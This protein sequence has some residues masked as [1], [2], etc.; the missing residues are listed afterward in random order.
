MYS[1]WAHGK[2]APFAVLDYFYTDKLFVNVCEVS[3]VNVGVSAVVAAVAVVSAGL[4]T[5]H[6]R[7]CLTGV[8]LGSS[9]LIEL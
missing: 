6:I 5:A 3:V 1:F 4:C 7:T 2:C 8:A 9:L